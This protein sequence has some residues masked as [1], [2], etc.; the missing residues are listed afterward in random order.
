MSKTRSLETDLPPLEEPDDEP[1]QREF[2]QRADELTA[3][4]QRR[5]FPA[6]SLNRSEQASI[7]E[8]A[9]WELQTTLG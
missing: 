9:F 4:A 3:E 5:I 2:L 7:P 1:S 8:D 6:F